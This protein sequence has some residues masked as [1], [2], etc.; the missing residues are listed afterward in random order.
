MDRS[1]SA[2]LSISTGGTCGLLAWERHAAG[3]REALTVLSGT[4]GT[5]LASQISCTVSEDFGPCAH[6][7]GAPLRESKLLA[8][9]CAEGTPSTRSTTD[10]FGRSDPV[11]SVIADGPSPG[12]P[13]ERAARRGESIRMW[14]SGGSRAVMT[15]STESVS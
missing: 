8:V 14:P 13:L 2:D 3:D 1:A 10:S 7:S 11:G 15:T 12:L 9:E 4:P 5:S 6:T